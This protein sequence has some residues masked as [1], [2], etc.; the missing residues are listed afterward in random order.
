MVDKVLHISC[1]FSAGVL[2]LA[3]NSS[4]CCYFVVHGY[5][6][7]ESVEHRG[8]YVGAKQ[9]RSIKPPMNTGQGDHGQFYVIV[10]DPVSNMER[11][12]FT[13]LP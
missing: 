10:C 9:D 11:V 5:V 13:E 6:C 8:Q 4:I 7:F 1:P 12:M 3:Y 2:C